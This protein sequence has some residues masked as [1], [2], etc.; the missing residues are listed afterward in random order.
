[1][2]QVTYYGKLL[3]RASLPQDVSLIDFIPNSI[4][5]S[6]SN[7]LELVGETICIL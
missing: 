3:E 4:D 6:Y 5:H 7:I 1:M 2:N